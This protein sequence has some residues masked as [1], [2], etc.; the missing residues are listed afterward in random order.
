MSKAFWLGVF[1]VGTLLILAAGGFLIGDRQF[2]FTSTYVLKADFRNVAGLNEGADVRV[3]GIREGTV[4]HIELPDGPE[5]KVTVVMK[6]HP[7][8]RNIIR[9]DSVATIK[10]EGLLGDQYVDISFGSKSA[11]PVQPAGAIRSESPIDVAASANAL[12]EQTRTVLGAVQED[13]E[14]LRS[15]FLLRGFFNKRGYEEPA[16]LTRHAI[17]K[18][19]SRKPAREF[20]YSAA[21]LFAS[22]D[23][24]KLK[25]ERALKEAGNYLE[26]NPFSQVVIAASE[27]LGDSDKVRQLTQARAVVIRDYLAM[28]FRVDDTR[29]KTLGLGKTRAGEAGGMIRILVY[30]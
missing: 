4:G 12:A 21:D 6:M 15:N 3:G 2:L 22:A 20:D 11:T 8:T 24:A 25:G 13:L 9:S 16:D 14:A 23:N 26:Q 18:L 28:Q 19:P 1:I 7:A 30:Q 27:V 5:D 10:T 29:I 17:A